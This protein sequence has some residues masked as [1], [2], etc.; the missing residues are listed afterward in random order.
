MRPRLLLLAALVAGSTWSCREAAAP[1]A[2]VFAAA[3]LTVA[4]GELAEAFARRPDGEVVE[5]HFAGTPQLVMQVREGAG[6]D[7]FASADENNMRRVVELGLAAATPQTFATNR[8]C[9]VVAAGNPKRLGGLADLAR[10]DLTVLLCGPEVPAGRYARQ[11]LERAGLVV[12]SR[13]DEPSVNAVVAKVAMGEADAGIVFE[14]DVAATAGRLEAIAIP[15]EHGV[16]ARYPIVALSGGAAPR[17]GAAFVAFVVSDAGRTIL[18][19]H[20]FGLP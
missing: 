3:S 2:R 12:A 20:G 1:R 19:K 16:V 13:S 15:A 9:I 18:A 6:A 14:T 8:P 11:V 17:V 5:L 7:V 10:N 4:F